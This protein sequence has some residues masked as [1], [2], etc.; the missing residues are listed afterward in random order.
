MTQVKFD[1]Q[2]FATTYTD[3]NVTAV[4]EKANIN[5]T[6]TLTN[7]MRTFYNK[8]LLEYA[9]PNLIHEQF[10]QKSP[11]P[12]NGGKTINFRRFKTLTNKAGATIV[13]GVTP[14]GS[15]LEVEKIETTPGQYGDWV[16]LTD[17]LELTAIDNVIV[18]ATKALSAQ[19]GLTLDTVVRNQLIAGGQVQYA[20]IIGDA[21]ATTPVTARSQLTAAALVTVKELFKAAATLKANNTPTI[22]GYY[23]AI[24]HPHVAYD[25]MQGA[26]DAWVDI[27][28]YKNPEMI[29]KGEI[30]AVGGIRVVESTNAK[31]FPATES[32]SSSTS[33]YATL[34]FGQG[35]YGVVD[36]DGG[37]MELIVKPKG[38]GDDPLNQR[39]SVGWKAIETG[40]ILN[41]EY[42]VRLESGSTFAK[43][44]PNGN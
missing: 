20:P 25:I 10:G 38:Y 16:S 18:G 11:I 26:G 5:S 21:G 37:G 43:T 28:K 4:V 23:I 2:L 15:R 44:L 13:E 33:V 1:L 42:I 19:A 36:I 34:V 3:E 27:S 17:V 6:T 32:A 31:I 8:T 12:K 24:V 40:V 14:K 35:A 29:Y 9:S 7:E 39:S 30:G 22:D 41:D